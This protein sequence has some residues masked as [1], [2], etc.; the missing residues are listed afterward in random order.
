M[1]VTPPRVFISYSH[2]SPQHKKWVLDFATTIRNRGVDAVLDQWDLRPGDDVPA[3]MEQ[4]LAAADF[5]VMV[6]T[7][8]YVQK[9]NAG[10]GGV[11][12]EK[13]IMT[14]SS[15]KNISENK[16]MPVIRER[17]EP[18]TPTFLGTKLY[19]D[20]TKDSEIEF[21]LDDLLRRLLNAPLY[22]K[23]EIGKDPFR[24]LNEARPERTADGV[25][26]AMTAVAAAFGQS[27]FDFITVAS[28]M[29]VTA[30]RRLTME[31]YLR[32][33]AAKGLISR[34]GSHIRITNEGLT[35][36]TEMVSLTHRPH[37]VATEPQ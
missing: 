5:A 26:D 7:R 30:V 13:M 34:T 11:G 19:I 8:R 1:S 24:P 10:E 2:D 25:R 22:E 28:L 12:Y 35:Y 29:Q 6:C 21:S 14:A 18:P 9:A 33:A 31:K 3:F 20:F 4:N 32:E 27:T 23:P 15:L 16:V 17:G 36:L 37:P